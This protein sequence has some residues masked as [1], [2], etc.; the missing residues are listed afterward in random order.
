MASV[1]VD[2]SESGAVDT[3]IEGADDAGV[4]K[5]VDGDS[6]M[7]MLGMSWTCTGSSGRHIWGIGGRVLSSAL[8][9]FN[10]VT[11]IFGWL[12]VGMTG[13]EAICAGANPRSGEADGR[14]GMVRVSFG[15]EF[16]SFSGG[17]QSALKLT[18]GLP[19]LLLTTVGDGSFGLR[20]R[21][22]MLVAARMSSLRTSMPSLNLV[23]GISGCTAG[24]ST[25]VFSGVS[26]N[27]GSFCVYVGSLDCEGGFLWI[28]VLYGVRGFSCTNC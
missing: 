19:G 20:S 26:V 28:S 18:I 2:V 15:A 3:W 12:K 11:G 1:G 13:A 10:C 5:S 6:S 4:G 8:A 24:S 23:S 7:L 17:C 27:K 25:V 16:C 21:I 9:A 14:D 22:L